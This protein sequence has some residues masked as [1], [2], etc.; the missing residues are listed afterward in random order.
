MSD[1][2]MIKGIIAAVTIPV[3]VQGGLLDSIVPLEW[4]TYLTYDNISSRQKA[5]VVFEG[6]GHVIFASNYDGKSGELPT[7]ALIFHFTTAFLLDV[8]KGNP[9]AHKA[10]LPDAVKFVGIQ[11]KT[12]LK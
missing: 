3:M 2:K 1:P 5:Q 4:G 9:D 8:L 10:L 11:Y 12:T 6:V 7:E